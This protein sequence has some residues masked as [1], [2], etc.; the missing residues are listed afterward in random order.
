MKH[1]LAL[2]AFMIMLAAPLSDAAAQQ[3]QKKN[4]RKPR[5]EWVKEMRSYKK[6]YISKRLDLTNEQREKFFPLYYAMEDEVFRLQEQTRQMERNLDKKNTKATEL[7]YDKTVDAV[8]ELKAKEGAIE[9][10]YLPKF[11]EILTSKQLLQLKKAEHKFT[12]ELM[13]NHSKK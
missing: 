13:K 3:K 1:L 11:K 9:M 12:R 5:T 7:E 10:K 6:D 4:E 8:Y 2:V